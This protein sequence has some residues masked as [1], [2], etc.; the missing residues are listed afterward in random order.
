MRRA[1]PGETG[2]EA[3]RD[4]SRHGQYQKAMLGHVTIGPARPHRD[5]TALIG[6]MTRFVMSDPTGQSRPPR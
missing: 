1:A 3:P 2:P 6:K 4:Q 5:L